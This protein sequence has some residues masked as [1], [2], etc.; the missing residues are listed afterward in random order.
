MYDSGPRNCRCSEDAYG[1]LRPMKGDQKAR[2]FTILE[3]LIVLAVT[4]GLFIAVAVTLSGRQ[5]RT[6]FSQ[7]VQDMQSQIQ[8]VISDVGTGF[9]PSRSNFQCV[10]ALTGPSLSA[11]SNEQGENKGCVFLGKAIQFGVNGTDPEQFK[12]FTIAGLQRTT[13][14]TEVTTYAEAKPKA[15]SPPGSPDVTETGKLLYGLTVHSAT[16]GPSNVPIGS[17]A[18]VNSLAAYGTDSIVSGSQQVRVMP[19]RNSSLG[20]TQDQT[21]QTINSQLAASDIDPNGGVKI[22][23]VSGGSNQSG[24]ITIGSNGRQLSVTLS[25][26]G[27]RTCS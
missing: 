21:A 15:V 1:I 5:N 6:Q 26:K 10:A 7:A 22:C 24:L 18:F 16:Y 9:Y 3:T 23:F 8:Q 27:N 4:A 17:V 19:V 14:G 13:A 12:I 11:G 2:G 20:R 25:I